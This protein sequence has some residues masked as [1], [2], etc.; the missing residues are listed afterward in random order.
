MRHWFA[1]VHRG[2]DEQINWERVP[3]FRI[4]MAENTIQMAFD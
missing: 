2:L 3:K 1:N 4:F